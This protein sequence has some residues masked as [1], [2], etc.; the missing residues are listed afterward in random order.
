MNQS[1]DDHLNRCIRFILLRGSGWK[2]RKRHVAG[3]NR[4]EW[5]DPVSGR[6][7]GPSKALEILQDQ[8][9]ADYP[10][11]KTPSRPYALRC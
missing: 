8:A 3:V 5:C 11:A 9:L 6:W 2:S 1:N 10:P 7:Y 4:I